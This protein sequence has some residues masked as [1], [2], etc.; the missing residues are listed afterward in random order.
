M[1]LQCGLTE[2][3][4]ARAQDPNQR[5]PWAAEGEHANLTAQPRE[6]APGFPFVGD[7]AKEFQANDKIL[8]QDLFKDFIESKYS[9]VT[10]QEVPHTY[11]CFSA[12]FSHIVEERQPLWSLTGIDHVDLK[13]KEIE[14]PFISMYV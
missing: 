7:F 4:H 8:P 11:K 10:S 6:P 14:L 12:L 1:L 5:N 9:E 2:R 3:C 13:L